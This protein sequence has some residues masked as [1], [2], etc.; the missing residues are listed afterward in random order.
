MEL[1]LWNHTQNSADDSAVLQ[2]KSLGS[3]VLTVLCGISQYSRHIKVSQ[4][5]EGANNLIEGRNLVNN[6]IEHFL[7]CE[8]KYRAW[9]RCMLIQLTRKCGSRISAT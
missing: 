4:I 7:V 6:P 1:N 2:N 8:I 9:L 5:R 3:A